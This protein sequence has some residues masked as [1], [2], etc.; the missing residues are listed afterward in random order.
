MKVVTQFVNIGSLVTAALEARFPW[1]RWFITLRSVSAIL[2]VC[3]AAG[4]AGTRP[5]LKPKVVS[6]VNCTAVRGFLPQSQVNAQF[7][8]SGYGAGGGLIGAIVDASVSSSRE[9]TAIK[10]VQE[11]RDQVRDVP[12]RTLFSQAVSNSVMGIPWLKADKFEE[13]LGPR[14]PPVTRPM[15]AQRAVLNLGTDYYIS[16]DCRV[17]VVASGMG[18]FPPGKRRMPTA[19]NFVTYQSAEIGKPDA[20]RAIA[21]WAADGAASFR[22]AIR[23]GIQE[24]VKLVR[25]ALEY[26]GGANHPDAPQVTLR[27]RLLHAR[28]DFG[29]KADQVTMKGTILEDGPD[30]LVFR[31]TAGRFFSLPRREVE[32]K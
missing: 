18:F 12:F 10:R 32:V 23:E 21:L 11:L 26:M 24:N 17:F 6:T 9:H 1:R 4:C 14:L 8:R 31:N 19:A 29:F 20:E 2:L 3:L 28:V 16:Q 22:N 13:I 30:R 15:V 5:T 25:Y 7:I 27:A